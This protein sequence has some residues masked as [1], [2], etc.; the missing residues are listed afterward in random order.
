LLVE[1]EFKPGL[2]TGLYTAITNNL[3][4]D[5][6]PSAGHGPTGSHAGSSFQYGWW[7]Y[8]DKDIRAVLG[9]SVQGPLAQKYCGGGTLT[10]CRD[11]LISTLKTAAAKTAAQVYPG[12]ASCAAGN[13]W[14]ADSVIH[15]PLGGIKHYSISWQN[16]PTFQQVVEYTSHR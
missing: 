10:G 15:R 7:S 5:E 3:P 1:A 16:R 9:E 2:G 14:C 11:I 4:I 12:D 6:A 8:V 13:Q